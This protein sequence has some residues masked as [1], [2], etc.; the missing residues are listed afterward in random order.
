MQ[1]VTPSAGAGPPVKLG[2]HDLL[3]QSISRS[4]F[5][6]GA[7]N[8]T[9]VTSPRKNATPRFHSVPATPRLQSRNGRLQEHDELQAASQ[10]AS[11][12]AS[13]ASLEE[14]GSAQLNHTAMPARR[15][16]EHIS[17]GS[18]SDRAANFSSTDKSPSK[19][20]VLP[21]VCP[22]SSRNCTQCS[23]DLL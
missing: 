16:L 19:T 10:A 11:C 9:A 17:S 13:T 7:S 14:D 4:R 21:T 1:A 2:I 8:H 5:G 20:Q 3:E 22:C 23:L 18:T 6:T 15:Q 12:R